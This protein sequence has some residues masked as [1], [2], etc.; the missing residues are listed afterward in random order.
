MVDTL[1]PVLLIEVK[2]SRRSR[3]FTLTVIVGGLSLIL[4]IGF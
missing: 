3:H 1:E 4:L 2:L